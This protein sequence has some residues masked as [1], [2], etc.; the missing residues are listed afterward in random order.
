MK[1]STV[2][3]ETFLCRNTILEVLSQKDTNCNGEP[4]PAINSFIGST[5]CNKLSH[6]T[7]LLAVD[8]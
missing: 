3:P 8:R 7:V 5:G 6:K 1:P 2:Y 4:D